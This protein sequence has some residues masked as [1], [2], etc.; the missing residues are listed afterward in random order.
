MDKYEQLE[1]ITKL[2]EQGILSEE[3]FVREKANI[4]NETDN[5]NESE[6][7]KELLKKVVEKTPMD[8]KKLKFFII[9]IIILILISI[10]IIIPIII[11]K[12]NKDKIMK[13]GKNII[14]VS[15]YDEIKNDL[16]KPLSTPDMQEFVKNNCEKSI[17]DKILTKE[18]ILCLFNNSEII[19]KSIKSKQDELFFIK[20]ESGLNEKYVDCILLSETTVAMNECS[21]FGIKLCSSDSMCQNNSKCTDYDGQQICTCKNGY[22]GNGIICKDIDECVSDTYTCDTNASCKNISGSYE[23]ECNNF[24]TGNGKT[25]IDIDECV[26]NTHSCKNGFKCSNIEK[27]YKCIT[28]TAN[29]LD[30]KLLIDKI[31][32]TVAQFEECV[33]SKSCKRKN[34]HT[35]HESQNCNYGTKNNDFPMN[36]I[37]YFGAK[38]YCEW[39]G[40]RLPTSEEWLFAAQGGTNNKYSG[41]DDINE[42]AWYSSNSKNKTHEVATKKAN[43]YG[44]YDMSGNV[45]EWV[46]NQSGVL[47]GG[48]FDSPVIMLEITSNIKTSL[49]NWD[50]FIGFRCVKSN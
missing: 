21:K 14:Y 2:K 22:T 36:C 48:G 10:G 40:M 35:K 29:I 6:T 44:I 12:K 26:N 5:L 16:G 27:G 42:V 38:E 4:L 15:F 8:K 43:G 20:N 9:G 37:N 17:T 25:C 47:Y 3:E 34:Y 7:S 23:C 18:A 31:E 49:S 19:K 1:K 32:V 41:S 30:K 13:A 50:S 28:E 39:K 24:Y 33:N 46:E 45:Q 11:S